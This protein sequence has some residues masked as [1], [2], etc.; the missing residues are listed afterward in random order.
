MAKRVKAFVRWRKRAKA[1]EAQV[2][3]LAEAF[4]SA[5]GY[6][7]ADWMMLQAMTLYASSP[8]HNVMITNVETPVDLNGL[9]T[10]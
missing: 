8:R 1:A 5:T 7:A 4:F 9:E 10:E 6:T 3:A 2:D